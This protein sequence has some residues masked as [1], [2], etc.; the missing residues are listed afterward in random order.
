VLIKKAFC[1]AY[2]HWLKFAVDQKDDPLVLLAVATV[3]DD[4][5]YCMVYRAFSLGLGMGLL[6]AGWYKLGLILVAAPLFFA[7]ASRNWLCDI[8]TKHDI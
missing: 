6:A 4:C 7:W 8:D 2:A 1:L 5:K 3:G